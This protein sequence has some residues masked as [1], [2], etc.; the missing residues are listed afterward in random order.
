MAKHISQYCLLGILCIALVLTSGAS[1][2]DPVICE[3]YA[4][5]D[6]WCRATFGYNR[7]VCTDIPGTLSCCC[8]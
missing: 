2:D 4:G 8:M 6:L 7:G 5:C 1:C 3:S